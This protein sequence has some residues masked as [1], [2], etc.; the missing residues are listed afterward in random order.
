MTERKPH[1]WAEVIKAWADG[2][3]IQRRLIGAHFWDDVDEH[4]YFDNTTLEW[5]VKPE[6]VKT[7]HFVEYMG[8][9]DVEMYSSE[10][11][12]ANLRLTF[13]DKKLVKAEVIG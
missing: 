3:P 13:E 11:L 1:K 6:P 9:G 12:K 10:N 8:E 4:P 2:K 5:R 7:Y